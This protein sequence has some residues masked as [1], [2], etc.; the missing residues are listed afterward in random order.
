MAASCAHP[1]VKRTE[2]IQPAVKA[3]V[4]SQEVRLVSSPKLFSIFQVMKRYARGMTS[5]V[6]TREPN[7]HP[8][9]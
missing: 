7:F 9:A 3:A 2:M 1:G 8:R 5:S 4:M 6:C